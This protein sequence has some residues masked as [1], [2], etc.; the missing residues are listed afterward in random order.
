MG[1]EK[2]Q[3]D[4]GS[5]LSAYTTAA[6]ESEADLLSSEDPIVATIRVTKTPQPD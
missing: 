4:L 2:V 5:G 6:N 3:V 1:G